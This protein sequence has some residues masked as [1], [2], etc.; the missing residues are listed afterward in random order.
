MLAKGKAIAE[1]V[2]NNEK[3]KTTMEKLKETGNNLTDKAEEL[4]DGLEGYVTGKSEEE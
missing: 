3:V 1:E 2:G 4:M